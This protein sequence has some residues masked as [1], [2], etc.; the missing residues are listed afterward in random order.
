MSTRRRFAGFIALANGLV[1]LG[2]LGGCVTPPPE[3][4]ADL[5][6]D[7]VVPT[8][9]VFVTG[10]HIPIEVPVSPTA[11]R[12]VTMAPVVQVT[13]EDLN[14]T[15]AGPSAPTMSPGPTGALPPPLPH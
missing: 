1:L 6:P 5:A 3:K 15:L 12:D 4:S 10:S 8:K 11:R 7:Q 14:R 2:A 13:G 9:K